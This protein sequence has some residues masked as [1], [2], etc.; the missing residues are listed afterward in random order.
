MLL[1]S[2]HIHG[3]EVA[4]FTH[5]L[6]RHLSMISWKSGLVLAGMQLIFFT[7]AGRGCV[8]GF[9]LITALMAQGCV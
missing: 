5:C 7:V 2:F 4:P 1:S 8:F 3:T 6:F 9:V